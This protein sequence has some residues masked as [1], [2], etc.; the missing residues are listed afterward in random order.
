MYYLNIY[1][2]GD[3]PIAEI[4]IRRDPDQGRGYI[5]AKI[6]LNDEMTGLAP[7]VVRPNV[8]FSGQYTPAE[9]RV[10]ADPREVPGAGEGR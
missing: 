6:T 7:A 5:S 2:P 9:A 8:S 1:Q 3:W 10:S 4:E